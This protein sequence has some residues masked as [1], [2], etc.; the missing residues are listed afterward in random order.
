MTQLAIRLGTW[1]YG[2]VDGVITGAN[3]NGFTFAERGAIAR[4]VARNGAAEALAFIGLNGWGAAS[5]ETLAANRAATNPN[6]LTVAEWLAIAGD[7]PVD[8]PQTA[9][10][11]AMLAGWGAASIRA[12][13]QA[14]AAHR[15]GMTRAHWVALANAAG[16]NQ[17]AAAIRFAALAGRDAAGRAAVATVWATDDFGLTPAEWGTIADTNQNRNAAAVARIAAYVGGGWP[18]TIAFDGGN[19]PIFT[20]GDGVGWGV[21]NPHVTVHNVEPNGLAGWRGRAEYHVR[22]APGGANVYDFVG[23]TESFFSNVDTRPDQLLR[24]RPLALEFRTALGI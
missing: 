12:L 13:T 2:A 3:P 9:T 22:L 7:L 17:H 18:R 14:Y 19:A 24:V 8:Y 5:I 6:G 10:A 20:T 1:S 23:A 11:F 16:A 4:R 21:G 15:R